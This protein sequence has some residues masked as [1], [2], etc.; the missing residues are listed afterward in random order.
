[1][2]PAGPQG[3][4]NGP[5]GDG[6]DPAAQDTMRRFA[7]ALIALAAEVHREPLEVL[8]TGRLDRRLPEPTEG[9][10]RCDA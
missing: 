2:T 9:T 6:T 3:H 7:R 1:M 10:D 5:S 4:H 8:D